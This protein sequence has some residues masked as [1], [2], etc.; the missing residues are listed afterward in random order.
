MP[1]SRPRP[2]R[3]RSAQP[4]SLLPGP[5]PPGKSRKPSSRSPEPRAADSLCCQHLASP[6]RNRGRQ[7]GA[8]TPGH[9]PISEQVSSPLRP[10]PSPQAHLLTSL[11][12]AA[13]TA[14]VR[15]PAPPAFC[16]QLSSLRAPLKEQHTHGSGL[17]AFRMGL[18][19]LAAPLPPFLIPHLASA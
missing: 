4:A 19:E 5:G 2:R 14:L 1:V 17:S 10:R 16:N 7:K 12:L 9:W 8:P 13:T 6:R 15:R 11:P 18:R 3:P